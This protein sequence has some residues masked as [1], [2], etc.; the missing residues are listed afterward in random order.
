MDVVKLLILPP[1][2]VK[3][4]MGMGRIVGCGGGVAFDALLD[5]IDEPLLAVNEDGRLIYYNEA[6]RPL[7]A[8]QR[9]EL[10][11]QPIASIW[12]D[13]A[14]S[15]AKSPQA[16][17]TPPLQQNGRERQYEVHERRRD[18]RAHVRGRYAPPAR[19]AGR[20]TARRGSLR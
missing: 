13:L 7:L 2:M 15:A 10:L 5:S 14:D 1:I 20:R 9:S 3:L 19:G 6:A 18:R 4:K 17:V 8:R 11:A 16:I 12:P